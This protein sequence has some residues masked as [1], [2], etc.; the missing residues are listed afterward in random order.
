[1]LKAQQDCVDTYLE[2]CILNT[3]EQVADEQARNEVQDMA[4]KI[5]EIAYEIEEK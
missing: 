2:D 5:N 1:M 3:E 4:T